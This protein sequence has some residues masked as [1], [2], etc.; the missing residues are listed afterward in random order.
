MHTYLH[1]R[2]DPIHRTLHG[3]KTI[4]VFQIL[5]GWDL[6]HIDNPT[7]SH[8][9]IVFNIM[10]T[11]LPPKSNVVSSTD[12][13]KSDHNIGLGG[14]GAD[15][16]YK[17][18]IAWLLVWASSW[19]DSQPSMIWSAGLVFSSI[20]RSWNCMCFFFAHPCIHMITCT[21]VCI[22]S[23]THAYVSPTQLTCI[24]TCLHTYM[25][26]CI[27]AYIH[28]LHT[29]THYIHTYIHTYIHYIHTFIHYMHAC[30]HYIHTYITYIIY[31]H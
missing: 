24:S 31:I 2:G 30:M 6:C 29:Y 22:D 1:R 3:G 15:I 13:W 14:K 27:H 16:T 28:T 23:S 26:S 21:R 7:S 25:H 18:C 11:P 17:T 5:F 10:S 20:Y 4:P 19:F 12:E 9:M 8:A